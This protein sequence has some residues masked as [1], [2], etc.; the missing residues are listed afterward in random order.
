MDDPRYGGQASR[1]VKWMGVETNQLLVSC[2]TLYT[3]P[4]TNMTTKHPPFE[5]VCPI[6]KVDLPSS[7]V[8]F[9]GCI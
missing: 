4:E 3:P 6:E 7:H 9:P 2:S 8:S 5:D 1:N